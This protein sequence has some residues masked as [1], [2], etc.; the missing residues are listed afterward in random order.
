MQGKR[1]TTSFQ[2]KLESRRGVAVTVGAHALC[3]LA[4][5]RKAVAV[6]NGAT[7]VIPTGVPMAIRTE[8]RDLT[9]I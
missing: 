6:K 7:P 4:N 8:R 1:K 5:A 2:R 3:A 9:R